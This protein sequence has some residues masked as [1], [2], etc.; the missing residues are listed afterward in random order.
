[1]KQIIKNTVVLLVITLIAG[2]SL[3]ATYAITKQPIADAEQKAETEAFLAV[4]PDA[5]F[6]DY[7]GPFQD[8]DTITIGSVKKAKDAA[9]NEIG[10]GVKVTTS[11]GYGGDIV[12]VL[13]IGTDGSIAGLKILSAASES[14]GLGANCLKPEFQEQFAGKTVNL[15]Y[16]KT[17]A[18]DNEIDAISGAT[19]TTRAVTNAVNAVLEMYE[20]GN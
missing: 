10:I 1:M 20:G 12:M 18:R 9:G 4:F 13:G 14:P 7:E 2:V 11:A 3:A 15:T 19:I 8:T 5:V 16:S 6:E 17:G